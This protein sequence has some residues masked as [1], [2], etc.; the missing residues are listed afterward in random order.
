MMDCEGM[1]I[2]YVDDENVF[3]SLCESWGSQKLLAIDT[4]FMRTNTFYARIGL[5]QVADDKKCYLIDP[6]KISDW[7]CFKLLLSESACEFIIHS[8]SEDLNLLQTFLGVIP[9]KIF[10]TQIAAAF[11]G[12]GFSISYQGLARELLNIAVEKGE[13]RS[14]WLKRPLSDSQIFYAA[15][16]V[17]Y[18]IQIRELLAAQL[19]LQSMTAWF[20]AECVQLL[21]NSHAAE[22]NAN[23]KEI[24]SAIS[25]AWRLSDSG[26]LVLQKLCYWREQ[27]ARSRNKPKSWI[28]KDVDIFTMAKS[29]AEV[30]GFTSDD[31]R[32]IDEVDSRFLSR[33]SREIASVLNQGSADLPPIDRNILNPPLD[34]SGRKRLKL[35]QKIV[36]ERAD[37]LNMAPE[38]LGRKKQL[39]ELLRDYGRT[40]EFSWQSASLAWR[41]PLLE[42]RFKEIMSPGDGSRG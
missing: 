26:L 28:V 8:C 16:D 38:L 18:L 32:A 20:E 27:T 1:P 7:T 19:E 39:L 11:L 41:K 5:L 2:Q 10:D 22:N 40:K 33:Y 29:L 17:R 30:S 31:V 35:L 37:E 12:L 34:A 9:G 14:D 24:Y 23:W 4:E 42:D 13:T 15:A 25:N 21:E 36:Q 6:L 3:I